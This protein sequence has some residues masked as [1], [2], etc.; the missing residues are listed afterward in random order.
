MSEQS[1]NEEFVSWVGALSADSNGVLGDIIDGQ[2]HHRRNLCLSWV[3]C[4]TRCM[5]RQVRMYGT[6]S[7]RLLYLVAGIP[8][9]VSVPS[10]RYLICQRL[11]R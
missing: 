3:H 10:F 8:G 1:L 5:K 4:F 11:E 6:V 9:V 2:V 7:E